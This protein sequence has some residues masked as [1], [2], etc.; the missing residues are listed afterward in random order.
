MMQS[1]TAQNCKGPLSV[2][3]IGSKSNEPIIID[4]TSSGVYC[5]K[6]EDGEIYL[7]VYGGTPDYKC[8]WGHDDST[9]DFQTDLAPGSYYVTVTDSY[10]CQDER[11]IT[12]FNVDPLLDSLNLVEMSAC[13]DCYMFDGTQSFFYFDEEYIGAVI[14]HPTD[15]DLGDTRVCADITESLQTFYG[16]PMLDRCWSVETDSVEKADYRF[17]FKGEEFDALA[18][19]VGYEDGE[20][21]LYSFGLYVNI[22]ELDGEFNISGAP[23]Q[24]DMFDFTI[25]LFDE[26]NDVWSLELMQLDDAK[27]ELLAYSGVLPLELISFEGES[28]ENHNHLFWKTVNEI[29]FAGFEVQRSRQGITFD[30][31]GYVKGGVL[32]YTFD[33]MNPYFGDGYYR[34]LMEDK[35]GTS[36]YSHIIRLSQEYDFEFKVINN[37]FSQ[38]LHLE[39]LSD[40]NFEAD[41]SIIGINGQKYFKSD[42]SIEGGVYNIEI[43]LYYLQSGNYIVKFY[44]K[45]TK[46]VIT[47]KV[48]KI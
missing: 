34:L 22:Y 35:D 44:N 26:E 37:P 4:E 6:N 2:T 15:K 27:V 8:K 28:R 5:T 42:Y 16:D 48:V 10:G 12:I 43:P 32:D 24:L 30:S 1:L 33:D 38:S 19:E 31:I 46:V 3:V 47:K 36:K 17:F 23:Y 9:E 7:T 25:T 21:L 39:I 45:N 18:Y 11:T 14:D 40:S 41:I 29:G 20:S 13:G